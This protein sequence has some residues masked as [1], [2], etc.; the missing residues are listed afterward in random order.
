MLV[1]RVFEIG[2]VLTI[3]AGAALAGL[4]YATGAYGVSVGVFLTPALLIGFGVFFLWVGRQA[5][6]DRRGL[7]ALAEP[8]PD[9]PSASGAPPKKG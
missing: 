5:R 6:E 3:A 7:L 4:L 2:G 8:L 1:E 9:A